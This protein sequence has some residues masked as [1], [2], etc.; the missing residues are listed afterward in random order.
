[1][2]DDEKL[3]LLKPCENIQFYTTV[4]IF[5]IDLRK[6]RTTVGKRLHK[7]C[8]KKVRR[9]DRNLGVNI[10]LASA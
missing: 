1:M 7:S 10:E 4:P 9:F 8:R 3:I 5:I 6:K 2:A